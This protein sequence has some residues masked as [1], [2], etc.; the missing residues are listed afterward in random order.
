MEVLEATTLT[1]THTSL[2][3]AALENLRSQ[4]QGELLLPED[5]NYEK[6]RQLWN[7]MI[8]R[9]PA[10]IVRCIGTY[11]VVQAVNFARENNL[12]VAVKS[13][14]HNV[15]GN[16]ACNGGVMVDLS[17]M[18]SV[19]VD[20]KNKTVRADGGCLLSDVDHAT[21]I[22][23]LAVPSGIVSHT[24]IG[25]IT[26][27]GGFGWIS[28]KHGFS[29]DN[30][31][32][33]VMVTADGQVRHVSKDEH[34]DLFWGI[35]GGG[36]NFGIVTSFK[37]QCVDIGTEVYSGLLV[38]PFAQAEPYL[39]FYRDYARQ[40]PDEMSAWIVLRNAPPLPF[41][42]ADIHGKLVVVTAF[43]YLGKAQKG[44]DLLKP[45]RDFCSP[46]GEM[47]AMHPWTAWQSAFDGLNA[48]G[49]RNYWKSHH[50]K[51]LS[52]E[53]IAQILHFARHFP[54]PH[55]EVFIPHMEGKPS[56]VPSESTAFAHRSTPFL[57]N[58]HTRWDAAHDDQKCI[59]WAR[60][61]YEKTKPFAKGVYVNF[62]SEEGEERV[63]DAYTESTWKRLV[64][65]KKQYDPQNIFRFN[66][67]IHPPA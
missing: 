12:P 16:A 9:R 31:L 1:G 48:H 56:T 37:F 29:I 67:N 18:R 22:Y 17:V 47:L 57:M 59:Q 35:R 45:L 2:D 65:L 25:G 36:G 58:V 41:L 5:I 66:Q 8:D 53:C 10:L 64:Q 44:E 32:S 28:R 7:G 33:V 30:L 54:T 60:D 13:G 24:G 11:D 19:Y 46:H 21:Q 6:V 63:K 52:D 49:M 20:K 61:F 3:E 38:T 50:L 42:P 62:L 34:T 4:I 27:G 26:L 23:G 15:A 39:R 43:A 40:L 51:D 55:C 14:G